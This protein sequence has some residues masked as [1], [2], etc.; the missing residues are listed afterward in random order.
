MASKSVEERFQEID[1]YSTSWWTSIYVK[2]EEI[3]TVKVWNFFRKI[4]L[5]SQGYSSNP[6]TVKKTV[7]AFVDSSSFI[8]FI[9]ENNG[10][11]LKSAG[12]LIERLR[13]ILPDED[14]QL[15]HAAGRINRITQNFFSQSKP[16]S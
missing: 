11:K 12:E 14:L 16:L 5:W 7:L 6:E 4:C 10:V 13:K 1:R 9:Q 2:G 15:F 3:E 8:C